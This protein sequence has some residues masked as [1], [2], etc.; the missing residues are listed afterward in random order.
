[1]NTFRAIFTVVV[2][3]AFGAFAT[4]LVLNADTKNTTEWD[5]W[6]YIFGS[7][8]AVAFTAVG[9]LFGKEVN[10]QRAEKAEER[11]VQADQKKDEA[12]ADGA[13]L[14]GLVVGGGGSTPGP[15]GRPRLEPQGPGGSADGLQHAIDFARATYGL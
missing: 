14:A 8:E 4:Y 12:R 1:M 10:R 6:V 15:S 7:I 5:H 13:K 3:A 11:A 9:W 2:I